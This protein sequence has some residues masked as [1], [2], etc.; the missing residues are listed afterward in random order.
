MRISGI[1][2]SDRCNTS[3]FGGF[4]DGLRVRMSRVQAG[5]RHDGRQTRVMWRRLHVA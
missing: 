5:M 3:E 2:N 1:P 4:D